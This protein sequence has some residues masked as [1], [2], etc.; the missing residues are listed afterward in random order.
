MRRTTERAA[1]MATTWSWADDY[2][3]WSAY[4]PDV[5]GI[6][7][8]AFATSVHQPVNLMLHGSARGPSHVIG[9]GLHHVHA[10]MCVCESARARWARCALQAPVRA[11]EWQT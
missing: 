11:R 9:A 6:L 2:G 5:C 10:R 8:A 3:V 4:A 7:E 1:W